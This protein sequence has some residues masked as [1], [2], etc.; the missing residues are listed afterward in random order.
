MKAFCRLLGAVVLLFALLA[1]AELQATRPSGDLAKLAG[2]SPVQAEWG[3][4]LMR[5]RVFYS[6]ERSQSS[7]GLTASEPV[8]YINA[9]F[10]YRLQPPA[11]WYANYNGAPSA[12]SFSTLDPD[13]HNRDALR[14]QGCL[15]EVSMLTNGFG[16][17]LEE[18]RAQMPQ[19]FVGAR[20]FELDGEPALRL[21]RGGQGNAFKGEWILAEHSSRI[22]LISTE[23]AVDAGEPERLAWEHMIETWKWIQP[24]LVFSPSTDYG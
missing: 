19:A 11:S 1:A 15:I 4:E 22:F 16:F 23:S 7:V 10:G 24:E 17:S 6:Y 21:P 14:D 8:E 13:N 3:M 12:I 18:V 9:K 5:E 20:P 2:T